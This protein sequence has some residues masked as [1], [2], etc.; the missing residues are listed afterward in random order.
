MNPDVQIEQ[1]SEKLGPTSGDGQSDRAMNEVLAQWNSSPGHTERANRIGDQAT[2]SAGGSSVLPS[3]EL[4][5]SGSTSGAIMS[6]ASTESGG[7]QPRTGDASGATART[8]GLPG[9]DLAS[10]GAVTGEA[11]GESSAIGAALT[12]ATRQALSDGSA[13][14]FTASAD[15]TKKEGETPPSRSGDLPPQKTDPTG[16]AS[17]AEAGAMNAPLRSTTGQALSDAS[18]G[19]LGSSAD[20]PKKEGET[21]PARSADL[22]PLKTDPTGGASLAAQPDVESKK[23]T[24]PPANAFDFSNVFS[25]EKPGQFSRTVEREIAGA[26]PRTT[27]PSAGNGADG[28]GKSSSVKKAPRR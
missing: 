5:D 14:A 16:G 12:A 11:L 21:P 8:V 19:A 15:K 4:I 1:Q 10:S 2:T 13:G 20:K 9:S 24:K 17:L 26:P 25:K 18:G 27:R 7:H 3:L 22:P 23:T 28:A 6:A